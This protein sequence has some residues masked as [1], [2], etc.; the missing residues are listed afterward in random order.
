MRW[1]TAGSTVR[2][3]TLPAAA[4][5]QATRTRYSSRLSSAIG[6]DFDCTQRGVSS[7]Q[8][9][10]VGGEL[11]FDLGLGKAKCNTEACCHKAQG[12]NSNQGY[13]ESKAI[14]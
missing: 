11:R 2:P 3:S 5:S 8:R 1:A 14:V 7:G 4:S 10:R 6:D 9:Y 12:R 13:R